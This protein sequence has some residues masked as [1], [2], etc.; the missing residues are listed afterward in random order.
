MNEHII[1]H[2]ISQ[3]RGAT[4]FIENHKL[5][6]ITSLSQPSKSKRELT[7]SPCRDHIQKS[8]QDGKNTQISSTLQL[9]LN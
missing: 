6:E 2:Q 7:I 1:G 3:N 9:H 5:I 8:R 4:I